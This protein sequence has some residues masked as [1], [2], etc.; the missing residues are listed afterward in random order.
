MVRVLL[1]GLFSIALVA[2]SPQQMAQIMQGDDPIEA[3]RQAVRERIAAYQRNP[4][5]I[6]QD[7]REAQRQIAALTAALRDEAGGR[8]G[9]DEARLPSEKEYVKYTQN[10]LS[11]AIVDFDAG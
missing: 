2:C 3:A 11:R 9:D 10:Y 7:A 5:L 6:F 1:A 8:W 4:T